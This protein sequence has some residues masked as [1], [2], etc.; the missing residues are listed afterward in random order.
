MN[1]LTHIMF[2]NLCLLCL[3]CSFF[4]SRR[5]VVLLCICYILLEWINDGMLLS[6]VLLSQVKMNVYSV[7]GLSH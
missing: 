7:R 1:D 4:R 2:I 3:F 6:A 5:V